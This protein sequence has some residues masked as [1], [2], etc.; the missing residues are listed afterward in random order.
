M[1]AHVGDMKPYAHRSIAFLLV[2][3]ATGCSAGVAPPSE[4]G[5]EVAVEDLTSAQRALARDI[6]AEVDRAAERYEGQPNMLVAFTPP[7][8]SRLR[9]LSTGSDNAAKRAALQSAGATERGAARIAGFLDSLKF[10]GL[11]QL[12]VYV[13][14]GEKAEDRPVGIVVHSRDIFGD[15]TSAVVSGFDL[16]GARVSRDTS[17]GCS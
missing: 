9:L 1:C 7:V 5:D 8:D 2:A 10:R 12:E 14:I 15:C 16:I 13:V 17:G 3:L 11:S 6:R 4:G